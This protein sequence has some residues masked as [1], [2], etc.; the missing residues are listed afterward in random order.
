M[1]SDDVE[2]DR[3]LANID[4]RRPTE[5]DLIELALEVAVVVIAEDDISSTKLDLLMAFANTAA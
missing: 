2:V 3:E 4:L 5:L 1:S